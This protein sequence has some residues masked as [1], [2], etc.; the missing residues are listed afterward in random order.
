[1]GVGREAVW[2]ELVAGRR[3]LS[4]ASI[5]AECPARLWSGNLDELPVRPLLRRRSQRKLMGRDAQAL[6]L[7]CVDAL[8]HAGLSAQDR[9]VRDAPLWIASGLDTPS[10]S[11][12]I[13]ALRRL[14]DEDVRP[15]RLTLPAVFR[16]LERV[17]PIDALRPNTNMQAAHLSIHLGLNGAPAVFAAGT[18]LTA[19]PLIDAAR[20]IAAG[21]TGIALVGAGD[22]P[23]NL[24]MAL[25]LASCGAHWPSRGRGPHGEDS[26][27]PGAG[28][29]F[30]VLESAARARRRRHEPLAE[31]R[32]AAE[33]FGSGPAMPA[34][35]AAM[36][37]ALVAAG[38]EP[39][40]VSLVHAAATSA[41]S[42]PE[43]EALLSLGGNPSVAR[44]STRTSCGYMFAA[45][46]CF[47]L[48]ATALALARQVVPRP[49][50]GPTPPGLRPPW[51]NALVI[52]HAP[53]AAA[54]SVVLAAAA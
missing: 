50:G 28:A 41:G 11:V 4:R 21:E 22:D 39:A 51:Q 24:G 1:V 3:R 29:A 33:A 52:H 10:M 27:V 36:A 26:V 23:I 53:G 19:A 44:F 40:C 8:A 34:C 46:P 12:Q 30:L 48:A 7:A 35:A 31:I 37:S 13:E 6:L 14:R 9:A 5:D 54:T 20:A 38:V 2:S 17:N 16:G 47:E 32:G 25:W 43:V 42:P 15:A 18:A 49:R 45:A